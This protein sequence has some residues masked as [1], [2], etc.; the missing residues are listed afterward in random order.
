MWETKFSDEENI[1]PYNSS[2]NYVPY[3]MDSDFEKNA[4]H[5]MLKL[6]ELKNLE[7]YYNGYTNNYLESFW[8][9]TPAG[10]YTPDFLIL[11]R[12]SPGKYRDD[13]SKG[14]IDKI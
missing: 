12:K 1:D 9:K 10:V 5:E 8:I 3:K 13:K 7:V 6:S 14:E 2:F 11:K 4:I